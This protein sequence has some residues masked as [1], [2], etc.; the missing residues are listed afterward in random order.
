VTS[1]LVATD[2]AWRSGLGLGSVTMLHAV[3]ATPSLKICAETSSID[4]FELSLLLVAS[5]RIR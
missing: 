1:A 4:E 5:K 3:T 2:A